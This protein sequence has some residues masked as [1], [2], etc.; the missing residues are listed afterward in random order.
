MKWAGLLALVALLTGAAPA[1]AQ[2]GVPPIGGG[3]SGPPPPPVVAPSPP[4]TE[5]V[6]TEGLDAAH[7]NWSGDSSLR[8]PFGVLW[9]AKLP[10]A[11]DKVVTSGGRVF[12]QTRDVSSGAH[13]VGLD[14]G[15]GKRLWTLKLH[16]SGDFAYAGGVLLVAADGHLRGLN[17]ATGAVAWDRPEP[18]IHTITPVGADVAFRSGDDA[19]RPPRTKLVDAAS[20]ATRWDVADSSED[21]RTPG[22][23][24]GAAAG[25]RIYFGGDCDAPA[26]DRRNG[27]RIWFSYLG[28]AGSAPD[29][30]TRLTD[31]RLAISEQAGLE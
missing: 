9:K 8:P 24:R 27:N 6:A 13:V 30:V 1:S 14:G 3:G 19:R 2:I 7:T 23:V 26:Y 22:N 17:P 10:S 11:P 20:G 16:S 5:A 21:P 31:T 28:C 18:G 4:G 25:D 12:V 15:T 29:S